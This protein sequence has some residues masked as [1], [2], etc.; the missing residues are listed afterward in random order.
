[1]KKIEVTHIQS[2]KILGGQIEWAKNPWERMK[3]LLGKDRLTRGSG[4]LITPCNSIHTFFMRFSIGV[5]FLDKK[6]NVVKV[7]PRI[8][9]WRVTRIYFKAYQTLELPV[10]VDIRGISAGDTLGVKCIN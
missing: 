4:L 7:F 9:P 6:F 3:G 10:D 1:M 2:G 5:I 8:V